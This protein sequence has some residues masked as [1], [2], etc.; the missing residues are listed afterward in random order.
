MNCYDPYQIVWVSDK[1]LSEDKRVYYHT[2]SIKNLKTGQT[3]NTYVVPE[4]VASGLPFNN[5]KNWKLIVDNI[6]EA[7]KYVWHF[8]PHM[9]K[10]GEEHPWE[11]DPKG[12]INADSIIYHHGD[13]VEDYYKSFNII[14]E[15]NEFGN[16][17]FEIKT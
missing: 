13:T 6:D 7:K 2:I 4:R 16:D 17:L 15:I 10:N 11:P 1:Y 3:K 12:N 5:Y 14:E 8:E 9:I